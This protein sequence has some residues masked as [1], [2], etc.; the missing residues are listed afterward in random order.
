M[1]TSS[2]PTS[3]IDVKGQPVAAMAPVLPGWVWL[4]GMG[5]GHP[6][7]LTLWAAHALAQADIVFH[8]KL[9]DPGF[10]A[11]APDV[12][13]VDVGKRAGT[14]SPVQQDISAEIATAAKAGQRVIRLKGGDP[15]M[16]GRGGEELEDLTAQRIP[17]R[18][19]PGVT[20][21]AAG[22]AAADIPATHRVH[23][24]GITFLTAHG[25]DGHLTDALDWHALARMPALVIFM[26]L[27]KRAEIAA[28]LLAEGMSPQTPTLII[29]CA[30]TPSQ[31]IKA[32]LL[33]DLGQEVAGTM[34]PNPAILAIG[35]FTQFPEALD[36]ASAVLPMKDTPA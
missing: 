26:P 21:G 5:P 27:K 11:F 3:H 33:A 20:V 10:R 25:P 17:V 36:L 16:F 14:G 24:H 9:M 29:G 22:L 32:G 6:G 34:G 2:S 19:I 30:T 13:W 31:W 1:T 15:F 35:A 7:L 18:V 8:D 12:P 28:R 23:N 4:V